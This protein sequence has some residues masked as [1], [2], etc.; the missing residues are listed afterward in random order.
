MRGSAVTRG[1]AAKRASAEASGTTKRSGER[2][3][4][5]QKATSRGVSAALSPVRDL[6]HWRA[7][8]TRLMSGPGA[9]PRRAAERVEPGRLVR[10]N[11][12]FHLT[13]DTPASASDR[14]AAGGE[15]ARR[16]ITERGAARP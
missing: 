16:I 4:W 3:A 10:W 14:Q 9:P 1:L 13:A 12:G 7:A 11:R 8:A 15:C 6:N 2:M 5:A